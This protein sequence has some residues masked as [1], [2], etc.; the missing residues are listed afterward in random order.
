[1]PAS[2]ISYLN[3]IRFFKIFTRFPADFSVS[4]LQQKIEIE[5]TAGKISNRLLVLTSHTDMSS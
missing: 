5:D 4:K 1:M 3:L 2:E